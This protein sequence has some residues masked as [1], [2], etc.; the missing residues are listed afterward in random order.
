MKNQ[1]IKTAF[2]R[3]W[4]HVVDKISD[5]ADINHTHNWNDL[6]DKPFGETTTYGDTLTWDGNTEGRYMVDMDGF[7]LYLISEVTPTA[8]DMANGLKFT[9]MH[10][11]V[12]ELPFEDV[13]QV[14]NNGIIDSELFLVIP[15]DNCDFNGITFGKQGL[16]MGWG[17]GLNNVTAITINGYTGFEM[18]TTAPLPNKYLDIIET[19]GGDTLTWDGD[20]NGLEFVEGDDGVT[21]YKI[22][23]TAPTLAE[24]QQGCVLTVDGE[25]LE[26]PSD[27]IVPITE[28]V[29]ALFGNPT[30]GMGVLQDNVDLNG[31][32]IPHKGF[33]IFPDPSIS[34][35]DYSLTINGYTG[36]AKEKIKQ[37]YLPSG[38]GA[39][40]GGGAFVVNITP[41]DEFSVFTADKTYN[42]IADAFNA[43]NQILCMCPAMASC[44]NLIQT[45]EMMGETGA[46]VFSSVSI[47]G[48]GYVMCC[49]ILIQADNTVTLT[50]KHLST[51]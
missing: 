20:M 14:L 33:Y 27:S 13:A 32:I 36:F 42:E 8:T 17:E 2:Q 5:K 9:D 49:Q 46:F 11:S 3:F 25:Q 45:T 16:Y 50:E 35:S 12:M 10:G 18:E 38:G 30:Y 47:N 19:V 6:K 22:S 31:V 28:T 29:Y 4:E 15:Q 26:I 51:K 39:S 43:G 1:S 37:E 34:Y 23:D 44:F 24:L 40:S 48:S 41:N 21:L 7:P